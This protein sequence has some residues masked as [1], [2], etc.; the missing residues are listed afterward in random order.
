[1]LKR[2]AASAIPA[3]LGL[4][5][6]PASAMA[7]PHTGRAVAGP[8]MGARGMHERLVRLPL[9]GTIQGRLAGITGIAETTADTFRSNGT[10]A[11]FFA[12]PAS[13]IILTFPHTRDSGPV[14]G[15]A[16]AI[17]VYGNDE[18]IVGN[19]I[20]VSAGSGISGNSPIAMD[21]GGGNNLKN[22]PT[23]LGQSGAPFMNDGI[24]P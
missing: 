20:L 12:T 23:Q 8:E 10:D 7:A 21:T 13:P 14:G 16:N 1:M 5:V 24:V 4:A 6:F 11:V 2:A 17:I 22:M 15:P 18:K 19:H 3:L 9:S